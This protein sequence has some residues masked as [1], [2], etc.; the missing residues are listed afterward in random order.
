MNASLARRYNEIAEPVMHRL[1]ATVIDTYTSGL[2]HPELSRDGVHASGGL[3]E[4]HTQL[5][6]DRLCAASQQQHRA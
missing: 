3:L 4:H 6:W 2:A 1:G 5:F